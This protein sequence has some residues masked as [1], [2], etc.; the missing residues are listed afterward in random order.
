MVLLNKIPD[1]LKDV[2]LNIFSEEKGELDKFIQT[3]NDD[4]IIYHHGLGTILRN[5]Y[6]LW[7]DKNILKYSDELFTCPDE[8]SFEWIQYIH[9]ILNS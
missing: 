7:D 3:E 5:H 4:L 8:L 2:I 1:D 9:K 6:K